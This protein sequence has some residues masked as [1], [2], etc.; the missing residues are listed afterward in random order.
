M[1]Q[2][3]IIQQSLSSQIEDNSKSTSDAAED[4]PSV[5]HSDAEQLLIRVKNARAKADLM[6]ENLDT[7]ITS[8]VSILLL[9]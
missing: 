5:E 8:Q 6:K 1:E 2:S 9:E 3:D 7:D 4:V